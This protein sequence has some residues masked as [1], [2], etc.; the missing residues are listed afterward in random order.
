MH[1][2]PMD[3]LSTKKEMASPKFLW[4]RFMVS[5]F[6]RD[7]YIWTMLGR[8][9]LAPRSICS[10]FW[11]EFQK[12]LKMSKKSTKNCL[13]KSFRRK[14]LFFGRL[15]NNKVL[16]KAPCKPFFLSFY[17]VHRKMPFFHKTFGARMK[18]RDCSEYLDIFRCFCPVAGTYA[19]KIKIE[20]P[21]LDLFLRLNYAQGIF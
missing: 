7:L 14:P 2:F 10:W 3:C 4:I 16:K 18:F 13:G 11:N 5:H 17:I 12:R 19:L 6:H 8:G 21:C 20:F 9:V 1:V 15:Q